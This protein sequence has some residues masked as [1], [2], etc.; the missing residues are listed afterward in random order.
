MGRKN[1][2]ESSVLY[3]GTKEAS[4]NGCGCPDYGE[5]NWLFQEGLYVVARYCPIH[6]VAAWEAATK[7]RAAVARVDT[8][9]ERY[10]RGKPMAD[11]LIELA[12]ELEE[13]NDAG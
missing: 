5:T 10:R 3:P 1:V 6:G 12:E 4:K 11:E 9:L 7:H 8:I 13:K 2:S